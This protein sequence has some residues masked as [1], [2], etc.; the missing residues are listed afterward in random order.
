MSYEN[1][2]WHGIFWNGTLMQ[3]RNKDPNFSKSLQTE[4]TFHFQF[5]QNA[6]AEVLTWTQAKRLDFYVCGSY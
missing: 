4:A 5:N 1:L 2:L 6:A 3:V